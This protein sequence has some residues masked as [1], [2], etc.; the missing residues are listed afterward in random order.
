VLIA[1]SFSVCI[2]LLIAGSFSLLL[3]MMVQL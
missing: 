1:G 2:P 3:V